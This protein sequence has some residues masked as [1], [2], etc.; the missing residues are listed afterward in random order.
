MPSLI[1]HASIASKYVMVDKIK[2][3]YLEAGEKEVVLMLHGFPTSAYLWRNIIPKIS[4]THRAIALD[5]P[6]YGKSDKPLDP[7][8]SFNFYNELLTKFLNQVQADKIH[9]VMH[10]LGG[11]VGLLWA[12]KNQDRIRSLVFLNTLV[13]SD[14]SW[15]VIAF[16]LA[17]KM[18]FIKSWVSS[19]KGIAWAMRFG[20]QNKERIEGE[21]LAHYQHPFVEQTARH[22]LL[23]SAS[24]M[25][26]KAFKEMESKLPNFTVPVRA[27]YGVN[28]RILPKVADTMKRIQ[29]DL[30]QTE[31]TP[32][33]NCGHFL[34]EDKPEQI[35]TLISEFLN[36]N[37]FSK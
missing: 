17:L 28:D 12:V 30:P 21:L 15:A 20:V 13:Y 4:E 32:L 22:A 29:V 34:Q 33:P 36:S 6:G 7:S 8:Y 25:S 26:L 3:H 37:K 14:F 5:L 2:L 18:P 24:N 1:L 31:I 19:P 10:D 11:P 27:I 23:K 16:T 35:S 9:L